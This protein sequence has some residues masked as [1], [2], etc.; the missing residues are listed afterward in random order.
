MSEAISGEVGRDPQRPSEFGQV[1][2]SIP[3]V[4][5][6]SRHDATA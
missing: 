2:G 5:A 4:A 1:S 3:V 6:T